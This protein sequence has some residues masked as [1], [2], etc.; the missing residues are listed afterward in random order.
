MKI[1]RVLWIS[2]VLSSVHGFGVCTHRSAGLVSRCPSV[3]S[4]A[5]ARN[6]A[7]RHL[8]TSASRRRSLP[9]RCSSSPPPPVFR[10][11]RLCKCSYNP[12]E[13]GPRACL[14]HP[15]S[16]RGESSRKGD[17][18]GAVGPGNGQ[19]GGELVFTWSCCGAQ[20]DDAGCV[21]GPHA[22]YDD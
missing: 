17:W 7:V 18:D 12:L 6:A 1:Y 9:L 3:S 11:C 16:L 5:A 13:N 15:G 4:S 14:S 20:A 8:S 21:I 19:D 22:S 10:T 2:A